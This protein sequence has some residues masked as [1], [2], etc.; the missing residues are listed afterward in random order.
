[1]EVGTPTGHTKFYF[2]EYKMFTVHTIIVVNALQF[3]HKTRNFPRLPPSLC[4]TV[5]VHLI[6]QSQ[7]QIMNIMKRTIRYPYIFLSSDF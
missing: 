3:I 2:N 4:A 1:M 7:V 6:L 5:A